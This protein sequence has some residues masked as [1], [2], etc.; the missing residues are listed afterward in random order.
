ML[1]LGVQGAELFGIERIV[2]SVRQAL[3]DVVLELAVDVL[4]VR[5]IP[6]FGHGAELGERTAGALH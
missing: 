2:F 6:R 3:V 5:T 1:V 4:C